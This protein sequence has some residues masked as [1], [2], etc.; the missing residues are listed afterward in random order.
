MSKSVRRKTMP[1]P[2]GA[3]MRRRVT[4]A[5]EWRPMPLK[6]SGEWMVCSNWGCV[7]RVF[8]KCGN[9]DTGYIRWWGERLW[10]F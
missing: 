6:S 4:S 8:S 5:P 3:G 1:E 9:K 10:F 7:G 2:A